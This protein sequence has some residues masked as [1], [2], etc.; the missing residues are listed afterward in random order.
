MGHS[1]AVEVDCPTRQ[2]FISKASTSPSQQVVR[3]PGLT[4]QDSGD[5]EA[6]ISSRKLLGNGDGDSESIRKVEMPPWDGIH[7]RKT[8]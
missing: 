4:E 5:A 8:E 1:A 2:K 3:A 7:S 6:G